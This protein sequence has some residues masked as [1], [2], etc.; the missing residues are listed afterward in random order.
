MNQYV[1]VL[2]VR[3]AEAKISF[4]VRHDWES[5]FKDA[6][7]PSVEYKP[8]ERPDTVYLVDLPCKWFADRKSTQQQ[9]SSD[10]KPSEAVL[11]EVFSIFGEVR[12]IDIPLLTGFDSDGMRKHTYLVNESFGSSS[13]SHSSS[14]GSNSSKLQLFDAFVQYKDYISFVKAMD[15]FRG[16]KL[17]YVDENKNAYTAN[18]RVDF[19][20]TKHLSDREIKRREI[21]KLKAIEI[22]KIKN[23]Q[24]EKEKEKEAKQREI[25]NYRQMLEESIGSG[26]KSDAASNEESGKAISDE[27]SKEQRRR[28]RFL[29]I[30]IY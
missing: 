29:L 5:Y 30:L 3:A 10:E 1:D 8:G 14:Y 18:I 26:F 6:L 7:N 25:A 11:K 2:K 15:T 27:K 13:P 9:P 12:M 20:R 4:P 28:E 19:D 21:D 17:L 23:A 16:M 22:E 24:M